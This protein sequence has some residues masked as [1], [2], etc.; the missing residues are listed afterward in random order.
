MFPEEKSSQRSEGL[1]QR[2][3]HKLLYCTG[4]MQHLHTLMQD[5]PLSVQLLEWSLRGVSGVIMVDNPVSGAL[6][7]IALTLSSPWQAVL[8][9]IGLL[10]S[11]VTAIIIGHEREE[12]SRGQYGYNG[13]L[14]A[15]LIG[16]FNSAGDWYWWLL[17]PACVAGAT[18]TFVSSGLAPVLDRWDLPV[19]VFPFNTVLLLYLSCT[20]TNNPYY[21]NY[22]AQPLGAPLINNDTRLHVPK[23]LQGVV[24]GVGQIYACDALGPTVLILGAVLLF[25]PIMA[26]H[27]LLGSGIGT[28]AGLSV[29][30][31]RDALYSGLTGFN[32]A[33]G[34]MAVG[35]LLFSLN[36]RTHVFA[37]VCAFLSSYA[38]IAFS[39]VLANAGLPASSWAAT[40]TVTLML[41]VTGRALSSYRIHP[42]RNSPEQYLQ[43]PSQWTENNTSSNTV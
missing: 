23:L 14:V 26:L 12:V 24:L 38:D 8:G 4:D 28:L 6:I 32:G 43:T 15:L 3:L 35:G 18:T 13:M 20:G 5:Q 41:L 27:A 17:L 36:W 1:R 25:S 10:A 42:R 29:S 7:L 22:P 31:R 33:L 40:L 34:C 19:S 11:T 37:I 30:V 39:N 21:P 16:A 2:L 9:S